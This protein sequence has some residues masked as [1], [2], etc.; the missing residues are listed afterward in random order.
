MNGD[1]PSVAG[2]FYALLSQFGNTAR[3]SRLD[4]CA[5][6]HTARAE[7]AVRSKLYADTT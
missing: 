5:F 2:I 7:P 4:S 6:D 3:R 1:L